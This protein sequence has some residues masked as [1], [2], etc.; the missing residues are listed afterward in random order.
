MDT[1]G[2]PG[3]YYHETLVKIW[4]LM[5][6]RLSDSPLL[7]IRPNDY[8]DALTEYLGRL[9]H[10]GGQ[11]R[12]FPELDKAVA[13][14]S[15]V[16]AKFERRA[17][18]LE[19]KVRHYTS[20]G[21]ALPGHLAKRV[22]IANKRL[23]YFERGFL[24]EQGIRNRSW[25]KHVVYAPGLWTGYSSQVFPNMVDAMDAKDAA[26]LQEAEQHAALSVRK[27][28]DWLRAK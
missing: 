13:K 2:D 10:Y 24:S 22:S 5:T 23:T 28:A 17:D 12:T 15:K 9:S 8:A 27:A 20:Q 6:L 4:G 18:H 1:F 19:A 16:A 14:L 21:Q 3:F 26:W 11:P 7:P 25:F